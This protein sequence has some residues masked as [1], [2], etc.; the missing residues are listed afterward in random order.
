M[1]ADRSVDGFAYHSMVED[2][3]AKKINI[4][5]IKLHTI[6]YLFHCLKEG[7]DKNFKINFSRIR[8]VNSEISM[9]DY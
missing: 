2:N 5:N 1:C 8:N 6:I 4:K 9:P 7:K 3:T